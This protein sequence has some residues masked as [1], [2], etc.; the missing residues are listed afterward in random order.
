VEKSAVAF[1]AANAHAHAHAQLIQRQR[2]YTLLRSILK[3]FITVTTIE[4]MK[5]KRFAGSM[6]I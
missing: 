2:R 5:L 1:F 6:M 3:K 4:K